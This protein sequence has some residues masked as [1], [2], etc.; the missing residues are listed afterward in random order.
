MDATLKRLDKF[1]GRK[2]SLLLIIMDGIGVGAQDENNAVHLAD[3][4]VLDNLQK[5]DLYRSLL[6]HGPSVGLRT[7]QDMGNSEVGHNAMGSGRIFDQ[8]SKLV[9]RS[10][11][12]GE[13]FKSE[14]WQKIEEQCIIANG[15]L[16]L[17]GLLSDGNVHSH[18]EHLFSIILYAAANGFVRV[19]VHG[20]DVGERTAPKFLDATE[21]LLHSIN[22][23]YIESYYDYRIA[24]GGGR[25]KTTMDRYNA[26]WDVVKRGWYAH[27]LGEGRYFHSAKESV[28]NYYSEHPYI[29]DQDLDPFII[30]ENDEPVGKIV[31]GDVVINFNFRGDRA[32]E[33][34]RAFEDEEFDEFERKY[35]P[36]VIY[37]GL[38]L[39]DGDLNIPKN[40]LVEPPKI[41]DTLS[42][43]ICQAGIKSFAI[44]E[45]QKFG[46]VTYFWN[47]NRSG[48]F[49]DKLETYI[50]IPS[51]RIEFDKSPEMK[52]FEITSKTIELLKSGEYRFGRVNF[53]NGDM[54]GHT[55]KIDPTKKAVETV[56]T[57]IGKLL[58]AVKD[59]EGLAIITADHGNADEMYVNERGT[60]TAKT[61]HSRNLV[62]FAIYDPGYNNEYQLTK[63][64]NAGLANIASTILN[65]LGYE[66]V[67]DFEP[68]LIEFIS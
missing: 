56:D 13:F 66:K 62:P 25:M 31:D 42:E 48:Y 19:R 43:Y 3:T 11:E 58:D 32:I 39:Y 65:L 34:S 15:T 46:H 41:T 27:V 7:E 67:Q 68:S 17:L 47:G 64:S 4:P 23:D 52:A 24:S 54:V 37:A 59:C 9:T 55:G 28:L 35:V 21:L 40:Y 60:K 22:Q 50:E 33:I 18:L 5:S 14:L 49:D 8:G 12:T 63:I 16:H 44:S 45:T 6:A 10:I 57:C 53:A 26:N 30:V 51:E 2:G 36:E 20:R 61:A 38:M 1:E 29:I